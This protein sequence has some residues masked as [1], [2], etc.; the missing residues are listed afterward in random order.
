[1]ASDGNGFSLYIPKAS[2]TYAKEMKFAGDINND[3]FYDLIVGAS[4]AHSNAGESYI[5]YGSTDYDFA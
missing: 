1:M 5:I 4:G 2:Y 3:G